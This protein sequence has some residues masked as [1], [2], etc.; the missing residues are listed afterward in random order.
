MQVRRETRRRKEGKKKAR[1]K[2]PRRAKPCHGGGTKSSSDKH[3]NDPKNWGGGMSWT[4]E[5]GFD[6]KS[7]PCLG[8]EKK[9]G[10]ERE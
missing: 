2:S 6:G 8:M 4:K 3:V 7:E 5:R 1:K 10:G 9:K